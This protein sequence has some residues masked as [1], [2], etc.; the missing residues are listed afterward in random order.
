MDLETFRVGDRRAARRI[1]GI[2]SNANVLLFVGDNTRTN[3]FKDYPTL[4]FA[5]QHVADRLPDKRMILICLGEKGET[6]RIGKAE[7]WFIGYQKDPAI[8]AKYYRAADVYVHA[9]RVDNFPTAVLEALACGT[10]VVATAVG[11]IPEQIEDGVTGLLTI[12]GDAMHMAACIELLLCDDNLRKRMS[13]QA[14]EDA[15]RRFDLN[16]QV[17]EYLGWYHEILANWPTKKSE[18]GHAC[19]QRLDELLPSPPGK[20]G[21]AGKGILNTE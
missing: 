10:P 6:E 14:V 18:Q 17:K 7:A 13:A 2:Q 16:R 9:A 19:C 1:L 11:G 15:R 4:E 20:S 5:V 3:A 8:V 12:P 21:P